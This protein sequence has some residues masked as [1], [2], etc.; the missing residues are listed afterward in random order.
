MA[1]KALLRSG[2]KNE[3]RSYI[4]LYWLAY[5]ALLLCNGYYNPILARF[6]EAFWLADLVT[7]ILLPVLALQH[8]AKTREES[9][10]ETLRWL[11]FGEAFN[12]SWLTGMGLLPISL[13]LISAFRAGHWM[14]YWLAPELSEPFFG[15]GSMLP[16]GALQREIVILYYALTAG[17]G[18]EIFF[19]AMPYHLH[20]WIGRRPFLYLIA[21]SAIFAALHWEQNI[22]GLMATFLYGLI[23]GS[24]YLKSRSLIGPIL[25]HSLIDWFVFH[26]VTSRV[27]DDGLGLLLRMIADLLR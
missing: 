19:R 25:L 26:S 23:F 13:I 22:W 20:P 4:H 15:Y 21:T 3:N 10:A 24:Y 2:M 8:L 27:V 12:F 11:N 7:S 17:I 18:E 14:M 16:S 5:T 1:R 6:P 9:V